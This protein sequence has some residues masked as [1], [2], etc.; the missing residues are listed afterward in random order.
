MPWLKQGDAAANHPI[1]LSALELDEADDR[2]LNEL[3]GFVARCATQSAAY[4]QDYIVT[5]GTARHMAGSL[6]RYQQLA[7][8]AKR[9]GYWTE[10]TITDEDGQERPAWK[11]VEEEDLFHMILKE[12]RAWTNQ[13]KKDARDPSL[14]VP[15][16]WRDG[17]ACRRCGKTVSWTD[18]KSGRAGTYDHTEPGQAAHVGS[19]VV[20]CKECNSKRQDDPSGNWPLLAAPKTP[21]YGP[22]TVE[23]LGKHGVEVQPSYTKTPARAPGTAPAAPNSAVEPPAEP[24]GVQGDLPDPGRSEVSRIK[25][26]RDGTGRVGSGQ[27]GKGSNA[28]PPP[29]PPPPKNIRRTNRQRRR[30]R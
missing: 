25:P 23:F 15:V 4:E 30:K 9:C 5:V 21:L 28:D 13:R 20:C 18:R 29:S 7:A 22:E 19:L 16:R 8:A 1:V 24:A 27:D 2:I 10:T 11:L 17:D 12:E 14:T 26:R 6:T 3:F